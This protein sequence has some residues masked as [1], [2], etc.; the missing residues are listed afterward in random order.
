MKVKN[1]GLYGHRMVLIVLV[2]YPYGHMP[3]W[4]LWVTAAEPHHEKY[5]TVCY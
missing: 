3:D 4:E 1:R 2:V 5:L